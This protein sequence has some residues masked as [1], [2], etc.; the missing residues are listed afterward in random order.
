MG[1]Q[2]T[3]P[4]LSFDFSERRSRSRSQIFFGVALALP[5]AILRAPLGAALVKSGALQYSAW[6]NVLRF[7][8]LGEPW[9]KLFYFQSGK[10]K[11]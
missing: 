2:A 4:A 11:S 1:A 3:K 9:L 5:L 10:A 7:R 6:S 8:K